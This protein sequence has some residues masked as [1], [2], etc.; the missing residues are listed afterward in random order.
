MLLV[1]RT[2]RAWLRRDYV[3]VVLDALLG[4]WVLWA[5]SRRACGLVGIL[6]GGFSDIICAAELTLLFFSR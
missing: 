6:C 5:Y 2:K 3:A 1:I 4:L